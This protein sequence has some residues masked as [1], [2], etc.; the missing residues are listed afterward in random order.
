LHV[1]YL[2]LA[3]PQVLV[4]LTAPANSNCVGPDEQ[5]ADC[6]C[7]GEL[8]GGPNRY[9]LTLALVVLTALICF[10]MAFY[11]ANLDADGMGTT[12]KAAA[13]PPAAAAAAAAAAEG[14]PNGE[15]EAACALCPHG[16]F[17]LALGN[18]VIFLV[19]ALLTPPVTTCFYPCIAPVYV[20]SVP[21]IAAFAV[22]SLLAVV[23]AYSRRRRGTSPATTA[24]ATALLPA[25]A[26]PAVL[27]AAVGPSG[28]GQQGQQQQHHLGDDGELA[29][30][31]LHAA[32]AVAGVTRSSG[33]IGAGT[34]DLE[35]Q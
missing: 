1:A 31:L 15:W 8:C 12:D 13:R 10:L 20:Q 4:Q 14:D 11:D 5:H 35:Q 9:Y 22:S 21:L 24:A 27:A 30:P 17:W 29:V 25:L 6:S 18:T 23:K 28:R 3:L 19:L 2:S 33:H 16:R 32:P 7:S 26:V 34:A